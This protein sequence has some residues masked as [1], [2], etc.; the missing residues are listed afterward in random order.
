MAHKKAVEETGILRDGDLVRLYKEHG[1]TE[2]IANYLRGLFGEGQPSARRLRERLQKIDPNYMALRPTKVGKSKGEDLRPLAAGTVSAPDKRRGVLHGT[3]FVFTT[4]QNNTYVHAG[5]FESLTRFCEDKGAQLVVST[6]TY[7]KS[8]FQNGTKE[9]D[10]LWFDPLIEPFVINDSRVV[11]NGLV[12]CG[13][14]DI[15]PTAVSPLSGFENY[16]QEASGI[17]PHTKM[18]M[19]SLPRMKGE[20]ER[21]MYTTGSVT[22]RNYIQRKAGQKAEFHHVFGALYVEVDAEGTW[23]VRQ[24]VADEQGVFH[25]LTKRYSPTD[26]TEAPVVAVTW[27]D[28]HMEKLDPQ[29]FE[30]AWGDNSMLTELNPSYQFIHD[31]T[32]FRARNHHNIDDPFF[33]AEMHVKGQGNVERDLHR[34]GAFLQHITR[35]GNQAV[36]VESN[37]DQA[38]TRWL[39]TVD[40]RKDPENAEFFHRASM[41]MHMNIK[42]GKPFNVF[43]WAVTA[44]GLIPSH[45]IFLLEDDSFVV[46]GIEQGMHGHRGPNGARGNPRGFRSI[47]RKVNIG[48]MHSAGIFDGVYVA[49]VSGLL[50]M[51]YNK[52]PSS[53]SHSHILTYANGK[54]TIVTMKK[55]KWRA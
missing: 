2:K 48:H 43:Q 8:G 27:G 11:T 46:K 10:E 26:V 25:D 24:L 47:G 5:F 41:M 28:I 51:D 53:W 29:V 54:R 31:L 37:H 16:T 14:L 9:D 22:L 6:I 4:A 50:D 36:V 34:C 39:K 49:G 38:L 12:F 7:N 3:R 20:P 45:T 40:I 17:I 55:G 44:D 30:A 13:E 33:L 18:Q 15:L 52:G 42:H 19:Q 23:F 1:S 21:F 35:F 32:D